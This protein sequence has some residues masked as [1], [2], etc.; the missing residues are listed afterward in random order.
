MAEVIGL[1]ACNQAVIRVSDSNV[2]K[3]QS[4]SMCRDWP[5]LMA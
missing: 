3:R 4:T 1:K 5:C 2:D